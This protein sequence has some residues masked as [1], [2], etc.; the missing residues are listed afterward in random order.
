MRLLFVFLLVFLLAG[1]AMATQIVDETMSGGLPSEQIPDRPML[2]DSNLKAIQVAFDTSKPTDNILRYE[3]D[4][5]TTYKIR[6]RE[7]MHSTV[8]LPKGERIAAYALGD[9]VN[10]F[11]VPLS[12][13]WKETENV[14]EIWG[15]FHGADTNLTVFGESGHV[16]SF[17]L[18]NDSIQSP[19]MPNLV[20]YIEDPT[21]VVAPEEKEFED[22]TEAQEEAG[23]N[24]EGK[25]GSVD[26]GP[27]YLRD[28]PLIDPA[29][30]SYKY[31]PYGGDMDLAPL[32]IFDDGHFT[33]F[34]F[35]DKNLDKIHRLPA[36]Y[37]VVDGY[38]TPVNTR[39]IKGTVI[40]ETISDKWTLRS[41]DAHLCVR[42]K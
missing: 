22:W 13:K 9:E 28:L 10:F 41:G 20:V 21:V 36:F 26:D 17:Y 6:L 19:Y 3:Y 5:N 15:K 35:A 42:V 12:K 4:A 14:F 2:T 38:D 7:Y 32:R 24:T 18:R 40:A 31:E 33:Y 27:E 37:R 8:V 1:V 11:F 29:A 39:I 30:I 23:T 25:A 34:Q 16:Y